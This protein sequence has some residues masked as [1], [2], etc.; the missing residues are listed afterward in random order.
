MSKAK[1]IVITVIAVLLVLSLA[2]G[3]FVPRIMLAV[4]TSTIIN[5]VVEPATYFTEFDVR[6]EDVQ[7]IDNG[8][9]AIDIPKELVKTETSVDSVVIYRNT[10]KSISVLMMS[11]EDLSDLNLMLEDTMEE[12]MSSGNVSIS[13]K[14]LRKGFEAM[15]NGIPDSA[16]NTYKCCYLTSKEDNSFWN[17]NQAA[18]FLVAGTLKSTA[19]QYGPV[20]IY[21]TDT[22][23]GFISTGLLE[24]YSTDDL[25]TVTGILV[26]GMDSNDVYAIMNSA[27]ACE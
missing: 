25:N 21:E 26:K 4:A 17:F 18:A 2:A 11:P 20:Q 7:T 22:I 1:K 16:Y 19:A 13:T 10:D 9:I 27:R 6:N 23:C 3:F 8:H 15:G 5:D 12:T 14:Q 24:V